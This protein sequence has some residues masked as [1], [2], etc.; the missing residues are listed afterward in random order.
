VSIA[1]LPHAQRHAKHP[2]KDQRDKA[3]VRKTFCILLGQDTD[4]V[5]LHM[6]LWQRGS[7]ASDSNRTQAAK[8]PPGSAVNAV[9]RSK[10]KFSTEM[11]KT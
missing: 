1:A 9:V 6:F 5:M 3:P 2:C 11:G 7:S 4:E 10:V 8:V